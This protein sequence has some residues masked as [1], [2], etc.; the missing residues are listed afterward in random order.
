M[1]HFIVVILFV[2]ALSI[3]II[4]VFVPVLLLFLV[5]KVIN[6]KRFVK[7]S[8]EHIIRIIDFFLSMF[9]SPFLLGV[10]AIT[11]V[12]GETMALYK[13]HILR[14]VE[15]HKNENK[16]INDLMDITLPHHKETLD[17]FQLS[18][19]YYAFKKFTNTNSSLQVVYDPSN[20]QLSEVVICIMV[21]TMKIVK[22][23][24]RDLNGD[25]VH[26]DTIP[27]YV[28][29]KYLVLELRKNLFVDEQLRSLL[30]GPTYKR[31]QSI[32]NERLEMLVSYL[33]DCSLGGTNVNPDNSKLVEDPYLKDTGCNYIFLMAS[34]KS[35]EE[36]KRFWREKILT[37]LNK[38]QIFKSILKLY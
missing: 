10:L 24:F 14:N 31:K 21:A 6:Y 15:V 33:A 4:I 22:R 12:I 30:V 32:N 16:F 5:Q 8:N 28:P 17:N 18:K 11:H 37:L 26:D 23:D 34:M 13:T 19:M 9:V 25:Y 35:H 1:E 27:L 36:R 3:L 7:T 20:H 2:I 38:I 29:T